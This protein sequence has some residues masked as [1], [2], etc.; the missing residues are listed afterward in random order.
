MLKYQIVNYEIPSLRVTRITGH[1]SC[2]R[3]KAGD[4]EVASVSGFWRALCPGDLPLQSSV[5]LLRTRDAQE[6][7][8]RVSKDST[9]EVNESQPQETSHPTGL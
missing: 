2:K 1:P 5:W 7:P 4:P 8:W 6:G 9:G 3:A